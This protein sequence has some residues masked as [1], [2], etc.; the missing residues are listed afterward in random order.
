MWKLKHTR[1]NLSFSQ[2][3]SSLPSGGKI[4]I[5]KNQYSITRNV[6]IS[7]RRG[8][9]Y[10]NVSR[11]FVSTWW[12]HATGEQEQD[13]REIFAFMMMFCDRKMFEFITSQF[14]ISPRRG[15]SMQCV[16]PLIIRSYCFS[17][18][19]FLRHIFPI[20]F[21]FAEKCS[22][23]K[24]FVCSK[25]GARSINDSAHSFIWHKWHTQMN[26]VEVKRIVLLWKFIVFLPS[27]SNIDLRLA[28]NFSIVFR[29][30]THIALCKCVR[31]PL[32]SMTKDFLSWELRNKVLLHTAHRVD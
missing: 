18:Y 27:L 13:G 15:T 11:V 10:E 30:V 29:R 25:S 20:K 2:P 16:P 9:P 32:S 1:E 17:I 28:I 24:N 4:S 5:I 23:K 21:C 26:N 6:F 31:L 8:K 7:L 12:R 22:K 19:S 14:M 3:E